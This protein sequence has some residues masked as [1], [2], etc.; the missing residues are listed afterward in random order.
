MGHHQSRN[1]RSSSG[2]LRWENEKKI[3]EPHQVEKRRKREAVHTSSLA[4]P[5][6]LCLGD[7]GA[8]RCGTKI[9]HTIKILVNRKVLALLDENA[10]TADLSRLLRKVK[11]KG[12]AERTEERKRKVGKQSQQP[13]PEEPL[14]LMT[15]E[16]ARSSIGRELHRCWLQRKMFLRGVKWSGSC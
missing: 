7:R 3:G 8:A 10:E 4:F 5:H 14:I 9:D 15:S 13:P 2:L 12:G 16:R 6:N 1:L 11:R